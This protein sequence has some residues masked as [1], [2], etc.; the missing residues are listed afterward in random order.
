MNLKSVVIAVTSVVALA[1]LSA[2]VASAQSSGDVGAAPKTRAQC[3]K[4]VKGVDKALVSENKRYAKQ[5][6]KLVKQRDALNNK[7]ATLGAQQAEI[8]RR[9]NEIQSQFED[10]ATPLSE[11]DSARLSAEYDA[12]SPTS[13]QNA[14]DLE[15]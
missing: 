7:A 10:Q 5:N 1:G 12:L 15:A 2:P 14:R 11:E 6:A 9:M 4:L 3:L 13:F 8:E